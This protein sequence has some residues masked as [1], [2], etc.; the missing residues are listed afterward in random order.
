MNPNLPITGGKSA[1]LELP[2]C[3]PSSVSALVGS[4]C[5][6]AYAIQENF[7]A[8][9]SA[10]T[11]ALTKELSAALSA[12]TREATNLSSLLEKVNGN[13]PQKGTFQQPKYEN[14]FRKSLYWRDYGGKLPPPPPPPAPTPT[15]TPASSKS[16]DPIHYTD[17]FRSGTYYIIC[18][19][20]SQGK[21]AMECFPREDWVRPRKHSS[22]ERDQKFNVTHL[23]SRKYHITCDTS[24]KGLRAL[25]AFPREDALRPRDSNRNNRDQIFYLHFYGSS[26]AASIH[27]ETVSSGWKAIEAFPNCNEMRIRDPNPYN[28]DQKF[29]FYSA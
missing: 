18:E 7:V 27:C 9:E 5:L 8:F 12:S 26:S 1:P 2:T 17:S 21:Q 6:V 16:S 13:V 20:N 24:S 29:K 4:D 11:P 15:P 3:K 19:T 23:G 14:T 10:W 28:N 25:E 22:G